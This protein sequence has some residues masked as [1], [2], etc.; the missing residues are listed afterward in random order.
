MRASVGA[1]G[2]LDE[3]GV[4]I[5]ASVV[6]LYLTIISV[7]VE[8]RLPVFA[9]RNQVGADSGAESGARV[10]HISQDIQRFYNVVSCRSSRRRGVPN[11][12]R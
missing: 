11:P 7:V 10:L 3:E 4:R 2:V 5:A 12:N 8:H 6:V 9:V 1:V